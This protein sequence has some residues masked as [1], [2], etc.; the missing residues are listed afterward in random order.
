[1]VCWCVVVAMAVGRWPLAER[2]DGFDRLIM[3]MLAVDRW[4]KEQNKII[5]LN[6]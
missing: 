5:Y 4:N 6:E 3:K 1:M 2:N